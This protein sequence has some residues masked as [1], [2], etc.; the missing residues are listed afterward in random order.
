MALWRYNDE[1]CYAVEFNFMGQQTMTHCAPYV[2][3]TKYVVLAL[4]ESK[5]VGKGT[6]NGKTTYCFTTTM[7]LTPT[8]GELQGGL[9]IVVNITE[10]CML[11]NGVPTNVTIF[12]Y[13]ARQGMLGNMVMNIN[14]TLINYSFVFNQQE[15]SQITRG[16]SYP[17]SLRLMMRT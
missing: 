7:T 11:S 9:P 14:M 6:W 3:L 16:G 17:E 1:L 2:N 13:P 8:Q 10:L 12:I 5:Y 15:F 4:N